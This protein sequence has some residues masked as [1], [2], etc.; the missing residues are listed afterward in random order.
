M[1]VSLIGGQFKGF[2]LTVPPQYITRPTA[3]QLKR[4]V[5][6]ARQSMNDITF[7]DLCAGAGS[8]GLE[9]ASRGASTVVL[10]EKNRKAV[11]CLR[12]NIQALNEKFSCSTHFK[13][14]ERDAEKWL[15]QEWRFNDE[16]CVVYLD[17]PYENIRVYE[18]V[19]SFLNEQNFSG[20]LWLE[21]CSQKGKAHEYWVNAV[22]CSSFRLYEQG[23]SYILRFIFCP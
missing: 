9:A 2:K 4:R 14:C 15:R 6:D 8:I 13:V 16:H 18:N 12:R 7:V 17:P 3:V 23:S 19:V 20:E 21:G 10:V 1:S 5:F 22:A 11:Q